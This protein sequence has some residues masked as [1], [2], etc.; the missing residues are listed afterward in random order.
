MAAASASAR[1]IGL[2]SPLQVQQ[3]LDHV[4]Y[5]LLLGAAL[6]HHGELDL[7][8]GELAHLKTALR[9]RHQSRAAPGPSRTQP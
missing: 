8:G 4:L 1:M 7:P 5:L 9:A 3:A 6:A 2:R